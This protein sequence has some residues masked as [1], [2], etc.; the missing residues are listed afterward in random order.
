MAEKSEIIRL[1][2]RV[3]DVLQGAAFTAELTN[4]HRIVA[5]A[6]PRE[7]LKFGACLPGDRVIV[8]MSPYDMSR[9]RIVEWHRKGDS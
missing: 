9:G 5:Y 3:V 2:A 1:D 7:K 8:E 4:G 6:G